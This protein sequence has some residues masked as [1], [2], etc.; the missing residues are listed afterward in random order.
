[1]FNSFIVQL[2]TEFPE[3]SAKNSFCNWANLL[4]FGDVDK[5]FLSQTRISAV[6]TF[7]ISTTLYIVFIY[8]FN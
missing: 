4:L 5:R 3:N 1:M 2:A 8:R 6:R 7:I